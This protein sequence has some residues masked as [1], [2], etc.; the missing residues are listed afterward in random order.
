[1]IAQSFL[2]IAVGGTSASAV[3]EIAVRV[4]PALR[5]VSQVRM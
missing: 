2:T 4:G 5:S 3:S 1:M